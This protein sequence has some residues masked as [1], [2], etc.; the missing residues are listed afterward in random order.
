ML[1][2]QCDVSKNLSKNRQHTG[3]KVNFD[4]LTL[5]HRKSFITGTRDSAKDGKENNDYINYVILHHIMI[6]TSKGKNFK[7]SDFLY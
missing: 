6:L 3:L 7:E 5:V 2:K 1:V 4:Y